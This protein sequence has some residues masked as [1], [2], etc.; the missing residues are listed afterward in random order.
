MTTFD[1]T[2]HVTSEFRVVLIDDIG[3]VSTRTVEVPF[4]NR[5]VEIHRGTSSAERTVLVE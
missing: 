1:R 3:T 2:I 5:N 4:E